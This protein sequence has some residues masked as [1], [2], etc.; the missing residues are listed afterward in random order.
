MP[1]A[2]LKMA[3]GQHASSRRRAEVQEAPDHV[4][5]S[6]ARSRAPAIE[7]APAWYRMHLES[8]NLAPGTVNLCRGAVRRLAYR[9]GCWDTRAKG[10]KKLEVRLGNWLTAGGPRLC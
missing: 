6:F 2:A 3:N 9:L 7:L 5:P 4:Y 8:R 10:V 1:L